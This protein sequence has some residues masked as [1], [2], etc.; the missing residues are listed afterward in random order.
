MG[1][2]DQ[3]KKIDSLIKKLSKEARELPSKLNQ[4]SGMINMFKYM[5]GIKELILGVKKL[6]NFNPGAL[7]ATRFGQK[8]VSVSQ[9]EEMSRALLGEE[10]LGLVDLLFEGKNGFI[11]ETFCA[12]EIMELISSQVG[13]GPHLEVSTS[14]KKP[15]SSPKKRKIEKL[16]N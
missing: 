7:L 11:F 1:Q 8:A 16:I 10:M 15:F 9:S 6:R 4:S 13:A 3:I 5:R 2:G 14:T 12:L